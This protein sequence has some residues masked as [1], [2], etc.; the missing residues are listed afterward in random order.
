MW[1]LEEENI[2]FNY[3]NLETF[4]K[5]FKVVGLDLFC[6]YYFLWMILDLVHKYSWAHI[7]LRSIKEAGRAPIAETV[8]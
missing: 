6:F 1:Y 4:W 3:V 2:S 5:L 8:H 7:H